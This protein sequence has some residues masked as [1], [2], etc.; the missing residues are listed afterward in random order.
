MNGPSGAHQHALRER[1]QYEAAQEA[2]ADMHRLAAER[3]AARA[4]EPP[5]ITTR[6]EERVHHDS[7]YL[8]RF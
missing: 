2:I 8:T 4:A 5:W 6:A 1:H 7:H 3:E